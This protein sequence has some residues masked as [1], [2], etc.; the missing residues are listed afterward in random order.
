MQKSH[1]CF[2]VLIP[3]FK[4][5]LDCVHGKNSTFGCMPLDVQPK[6]GTA[7]AL[8]GHLTITQPKHTAGVTASFL[9]GKPLRVIVLKSPTNF[10]RG[11]PQTA[12]L[13]A[14]ARDGNSSCVAP[15]WFHKRSLPPDVSALQEVSQTHWL[16]TPYSPN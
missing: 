3:S 15:Q 12:L 8:H 16:V 13:S 2:L 1:F 10:C 4:K 7:A 6:S 5:D 11:A 14:G 9:R